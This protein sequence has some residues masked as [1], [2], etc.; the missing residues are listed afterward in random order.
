MSHLNLSSVLDHTA[1]LT[2]DRIA[3]TCGPQQLTYAELDTRA[4]RLARRLRRLGV[5]PE[6]PATF[7]LERSAEM[8][9]ANRQTPRAA[10]RVPRITGMHSSRKDGR[11]IPESSG[12]ARRDQAAVLEFRTSCPGSP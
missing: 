1:R 8:I 7:L 6:V 4:D 3:I 9:V 5:G 10:A 11:T 2:P 12:Q